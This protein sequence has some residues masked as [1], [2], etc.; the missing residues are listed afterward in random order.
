MDVARLI[1]E[2]L[3]ALIWPVTVL[4]AVLMF[5]REIKT[6][7][8]RIKKAVLPGG[9]S[10]DL[11]QDIR[12][13]TELATRI[14]ANPRPR[15]PNEPAALPLTEANSRMIE[16]GLVPV[17]SGLDLDYYKSIAERDPTLALAGLRIELEILLRNLARGFKI[18][19]PGYQSPLQLLKSLRDGSRITSDQYELGRQIFSLANRAI[20]G[21]T[22]SRNEAEQI[23]ESSKAL[24]D[25]YLAWLSWG[26]GGGWNPPPKP[27]CE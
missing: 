25:D 7:L 3:K 20:H 26:F 1:L 14:E 27:D 22:V 17:P 11:E 12:E 16:L 2:Y 19:R 8:A 15:G 6:I 4:T 21:Q 10:F 5:R 9:V 23:I 13:T 18:E 24:I